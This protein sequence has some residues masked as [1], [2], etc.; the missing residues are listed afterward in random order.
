MLREAWHQTTVL[1]SST[2]IVCFHRRVY[3][4]NS[5][6]STQQCFVTSDYQRIQIWSSAS[7]QACLW[8]HNIL[9]LYSLSDK[10]KVKVNTFILSL[11]YMPDVELCVAKSHLCPL[12]ELLSKNA[13]RPLHDCEIPIEQNRV[14]NVP[15][16]MCCQVLSMDWMC[17]LAFILKAAM[18]ELRS[19]SSSG[20]FS[21][22]TGGHWW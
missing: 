22:N 8:K 15:H 7:L 2:A 9:F 6:I 10:F 4:L 11:D 19:T 5:T 3:G 16:Y 13:F 14:Q 17:S 1:R 18:L 20:Y 21:L 12:A